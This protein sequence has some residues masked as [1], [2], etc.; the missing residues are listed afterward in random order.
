MMPMEISSEERAV[1]G[2]FRRTFGYWLSPISRDQV[3]WGPSKY[4]ICGTIIENDHVVELWIYKWGLKIIPNSIGR[5]YTLEKLIL[6]D[7]ELEEVPSSIGTLVNLKELN[8]SYNNLD[9]GV[10]ASLGRLRNL[11][12]LDLSGNR[13]EKLPSSLGNLAN[14]E[15]LNV[16]RNQLD[17]LPTSFKKLQTLKILHLEGNPSLM[18]SE[19]VELLPALEKITLSKEP[20]I[21]PIIEKLQRKGVEVELVFIAEE[22]EQ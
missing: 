18:Y 16:S 22:W 14:L 4:A 5:L 1:L 21:D 6:S 10:P 2:D 17:K 12:K 20:V 11:K 3:A 15:E 7:N 19:F 8:L 13:M 9:N